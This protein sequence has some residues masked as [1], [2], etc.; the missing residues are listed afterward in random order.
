MPLPVRGHPFSRFGLDPRELRRLEADP[1]DRSL[2]RLAVA[3]GEV[4]LRIALED[5]DERGVVA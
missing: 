1:V 4:R 3:F 2:N 5:R